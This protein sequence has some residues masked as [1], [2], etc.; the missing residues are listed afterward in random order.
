MSLRAAFL[1]VAATV[2]LHI[3]FLP[4]V[5]LLIGYGI[6][7]DIDQWLAKRARTKAL[8]K[9][10]DEE[11]FGWEPDPNKPEYENW[12]NLTRRRLTGND[13]IIVTR[14]AEILRRMPGAP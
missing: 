12:G 14:V 2:I 7:A 4:T 9:L 3:S 5:A 8:T 6:C 1:I 10:F 13:Q 11:I